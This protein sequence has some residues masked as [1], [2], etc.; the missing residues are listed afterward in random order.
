MFRKNGHKYQEARGYEFEKEHPIQRRPTRKWEV[1]K[2]LGAKDGNRGAMNGGVY[3]VKDRVTGETCVEKRSTRE[4]VRTKLVRQEIIILR[5]LSDPGHMHVT[6]MVDHF[7]DKSQGLASI[8]LEHCDVGGLNVFLKWRLEQG[9]LFNESDVWEWFIQLFD[10]L[11][12]CHYGPNPEERFKNRTQ[13]DWKGSWD[14][15][16]HRDI[17]VDNI[18]VTRGSRPDHE[19]GYLMKIADFGC[20]VARRHIWADVRNKRKR[21]SACTPGWQPP[22]SPEFTARSDVWQLG[23]VMACICNIMVSPHFDTNNPAPG[24]TQTLKYAIRDTLEPDH[25]KRPKADEV[26]GFVKKKFESIKE[27]LKKNPMPVPIKIDYVKLNR[28]HNAARQMKFHQRPPR[29]PRQHSEPRGFNPRLDGLK[30]FGE[31]DDH[32]GSLG[33]RRPGEMGTF[34]YGQGIFEGMRGFGRMH[35][36]DG[37]RSDEELFDV[38]MGAFYDDP[39]D[40]LMF[41]RRFGSP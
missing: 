17:K 3:I 23:A 6:R 7:L 27:K 22:E 12:Y 5:Y 13:R 26:L 37:Y 25:L 4:I 21:V 40:H 2:K 9:E 10:G 38:G 34:N 8:Y 30:P 28:K 11:T 16:F 35:V 20:G 31:Y 33:L 36:P 19:T 14:T 39:D 32:F 18:L 1:V 24:Y 29:R 41:N 15:V